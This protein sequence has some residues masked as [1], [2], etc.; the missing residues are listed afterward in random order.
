MY[1]FPVSPLESVR[2]FL[3][4]LKTAGEGCKILWGEDL[5]KRYSVFKELFLT[6]FAGQ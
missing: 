2:L 3:S 5:A 6:A 4:G 1:R